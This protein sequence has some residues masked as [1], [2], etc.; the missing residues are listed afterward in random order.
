MVLYSTTIKKLE[1]LGFSHLI[2]FTHGP[3]Y[4]PWHS[5]GRSK[6]LAFFLHPLLCFANFL[7]LLS[8]SRPFLASATLLGSLN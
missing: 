4:D 2:P 1:T 6:G 7:H 8:V 3:K 5:W